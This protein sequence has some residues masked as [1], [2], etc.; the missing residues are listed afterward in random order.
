[1][2]DLRPLIRVR[3][4]ALEQKQKFLAELYRQAEELNG[5]KSTLELQLQDERR[6]LDELN[7]VEMLSYF[8]AYSEAVKERIAEI[9]HGIEALNTRIH[10][11]QED[12]RESFANL[13]KIEM[14]QEA[15]E[16]AEEAEREKRETGTL[17]EIGLEGFRRKTEEEK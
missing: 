6:R 16:E 13:K 17:N 10:R 4:H 15:R 2:A 5:Q 11:A 8:G 7:M 1:M 9:A 14:A 3:K 12:M